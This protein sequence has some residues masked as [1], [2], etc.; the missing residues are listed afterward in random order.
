[1]EA[2]NRADGTTTPAVKKMR[3][4]SN[5]AFRSALKRAGI[6]NRRFHDLRYTSVV[7]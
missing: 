2:K 5:T 7:G 6:E 4:D 1:M 3:V